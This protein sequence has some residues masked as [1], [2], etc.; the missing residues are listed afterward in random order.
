ML[1]RHFGHLEVVSVWSLFG[2][3]GCTLVGLLLGLGHISNSG[4]SAMLVWRLRIHL[5]EV[6][7][8]RSSG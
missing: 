2:R 7:S 6:F 3:V 4:L 5:Q 8:W 1:R